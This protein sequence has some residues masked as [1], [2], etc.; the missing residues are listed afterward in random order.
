MKYTFEDAVKEDNQI[1]RDFKAYFFVPDQSH[2]NDFEMRFCSETV[3]E[4][5]YRTNLHIYRFNFSDAKIHR[6][7]LC[8]VSDSE[9]VKLA[10]SL[11]PYGIV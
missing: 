6:S 4:K 9:K 3:S 5:T 2:K 8:R 1:K 11:E 10:L 7:R